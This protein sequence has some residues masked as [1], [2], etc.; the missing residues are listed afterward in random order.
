MKALCWNGTRKLDVE[1]VSDP[2]ILNPKDAIIRVALSS[3]C[4]SDLHLVNGFIPT[5]KAGDIIGN[6]FNG[7]VVEVGRE[8]KK[9]KKG[10]RVVVGSVIGCG[11]CYYCTHD[12]WSLCD[13]SNPNG[14]VQ[15]KLFGY[16]TAA[17]YGY[18]HL[19]GGYAGS[20]AEY[21][22][23]AYADNGCF[24]IPDGISWEQSLFA[25]DALPT[26]YMAADMAVKPGDVVAVWGAGGVGL[27][28]M[29]SAWLKG[30]SRVI[31]IDRFDYRLAYAKKEAKAE[32]INYEE[33]GVLE[34]LKE[35][36]GGRGPD[37]CI[38]AVGLEAR[39]S[40]KLEYAYDKLKQNLRLQ[41]DRA[42]VLRQSILACRK[43]GTV[44]VVGV[45]SSLVDSFPMGIL[46]NKAL[47]IKSGQMHAQKYIP[48]LLELVQKGALDPSFL[49]THKWPLDAGAE[50]YKMFNDKTDGCMRVAFNPGSLA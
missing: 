27:M 16:P 8:V 12:E 29:K 11:E 40:N 38:D 13:N 32:V 50:G 33:T 25:S 44:S 1:R 15:E 36:T 5:M 22:R 31:A 49:L 18:S 17:I 39:S 48:Y 3:V 4:G 34:E 37:V 21:I 41:P 30:A 43:G 20:H 23:V 2:S 9:L 47:T 26:G 7:E 46:M 35:L 24:K 42:A 19:F 6:E 10:D 14:H 28:A 45:Y